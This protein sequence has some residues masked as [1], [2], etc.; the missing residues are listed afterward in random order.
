LDR[1]R[2]FDAVYLMRA[3]H[4]APMVLNG[5]VA[6]QWGGGVGWPNF[7]KIMQAGGRLVGFSDDQ[8]KKINAKYSFLQPLT[9]PAGSYPGH[10]EP[11]QTVGSFRFLLARP[12]L[13]EALAY[14]L[15]KAIHKGQ[16]KLAG[17][18]TQGRETLPG[19]TWNAAG[20]PDRIH[21]G[22]RRYLTELG[23]N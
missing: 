5:E 6:A 16:P 8:I 22:A 4:G 9:I 2:D 13:P 12:D 10:A 1:D 11:P 21:P 3:G 18:P 17:R 14:R 19:N 7:T 20:N 15:A 23:Y